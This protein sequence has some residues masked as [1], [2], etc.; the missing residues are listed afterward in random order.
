MIF[1]VRKREVIRIC[2]LVVERSNIVKFPVDMAWDRFCVKVKEIQHS[3]CVTK[4]IPLTFYVTEKDAETIRGKAAS[5][6][7][8]LT[9]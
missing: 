2:A 7:M 4:P 8:D 9:R 5:S 1:C 6:G 3:L